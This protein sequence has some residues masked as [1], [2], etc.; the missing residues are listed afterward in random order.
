MDLESGSTETLEEERG[1][2]DLV[3]MAD[4]PLQRVVSV[5]RV[6]FCSQI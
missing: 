3:W 5:E 6:L 2:S 4:M 1:V